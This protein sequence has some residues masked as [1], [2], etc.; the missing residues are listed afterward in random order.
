MELKRKLL[1]LE[2]IEFIQAPKRSKDGEG[3]RGSSS[4][5]SDP[6]SNDLPAPCQSKDAVASQEGKGTD[7]HIAEG[8]ETDV[9]NKILPSQ[10]AEEAQ[11]GAIVPVGGG[12]QNGGSDLPN[13]VTHY[14]AWRRFAT[15]CKAKSRADTNAAKQFAAGGKLAHQAFLTF[16]EAWSC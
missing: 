6:G 12:A 13:S 16:L 2:A 11:G 3:A 14:D 1:E 4:S 9:N 7:E 8:Q 5:A 15:K 10:G